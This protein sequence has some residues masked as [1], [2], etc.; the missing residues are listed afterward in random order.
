MQGPW[1]YDDS[2]GGPTVVPLRPMERE[3]EPPGDAQRDGR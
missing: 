3:D 2:M 1:S